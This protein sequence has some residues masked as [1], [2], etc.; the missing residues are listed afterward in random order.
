[1]ITTTVDTIWKVM[2]VYLPRVPVGAAILIGFWA[3]GRVLQ[4]IIVRF[5]VARRADSSL[6]LFLGRA[7]KVIAI[8]F[9]IITAAGTLGVDVTSLVAG[10]GLTGLTLGLALKDSLT[11]AVS[12]ILL[13]VYQPFAS[14]D[15][16]AMTN[17]EGKVLEINLR[18]TVLDTGEKKVFIP[19]SLLFTTPITVDGSQPGA[20]GH[21]SPSAPI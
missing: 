20:P 9:G 8:V 3:S 21:P 10:L 12:G 13:I 17:F 18:Y 4:G 5:G 1:M 11:N 7:A 6:A 19:N 14:H 15:R 2:L 16:I